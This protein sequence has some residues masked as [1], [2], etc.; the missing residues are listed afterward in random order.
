MT[1]FVLA[2]QADFSVVHFTFRVPWRATEHT[3][4]PSVFLSTR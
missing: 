1:G 2:K 3:C 4:R